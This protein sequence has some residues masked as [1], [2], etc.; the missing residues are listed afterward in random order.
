M[1]LVLFPPI[2]ISQ[3]GHVGGASATK[4]PKVLPPSFCWIVNQLGCTDEA[5]NGVELRGSHAVFSSRL[6]I[7][8]FF[9]VCRDQIWEENSDFR[10][11]AVCVFA[12]ITRLW[13]FLIFAEVFKKKFWGDKVMIKVSSITSVKLHVSQDGN[14]LHHGCKCFICQFAHIEWKISGRRIFAP[15]DFA[16][17]WLRPKGSTGTANVQVVVVQMICRFRSGYVIYL[18]ELQILHS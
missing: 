7:C 4:H 5:R 11:S 15:V 12:T 6:C 16:Y 1:L 10:N 9:C 3:Q 8:S 2:S 14:L 18:C 17:L 13:S